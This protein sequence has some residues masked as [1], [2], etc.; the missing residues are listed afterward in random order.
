MHSGRGLGAKF[1]EAN[2]HAQREGARYGVQ[3]II[4]GEKCGAQYMEGGGGA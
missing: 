3:S 2:K 4:E 1:G